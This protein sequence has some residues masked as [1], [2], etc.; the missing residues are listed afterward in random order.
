MW[1]SPAFASP[2][3]PKQCLS[4]QKPLPKKGISQSNKCP[5]PTSQVTPTN[6]PKH[7]PL[8]RDRSTRT[9]TP[10][11]DHPGGPR[12]A[13]GA[14]QQRKALSLGG[15]LPTS[16]TLPDGYGSPIPTDRWV[17]SHRRK[18]R[19]GGRWG[20]AG[21]SWGTGETF[22]VEKNTS[23][24]DN[25][26]AFFFFFCFCYL[27][28]YRILLGGFSRNREKEIDRSSPAGRCKGKRHHPVIEPR[29]LVHQLHLSRSSVPRRKRMI[30]NE[31]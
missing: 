11:G 16:G 15:T 4:P 7:G 2:K 1:N 12:H 17:S 6:A 19:W 14:Q 24:L 13:Q 29:H 20:V 22:R 23:T 10:G 3:P 26:S 9:A 30:P 5:P 8:H 18:G 25:G 31:S 27:C 21:G 28:Q